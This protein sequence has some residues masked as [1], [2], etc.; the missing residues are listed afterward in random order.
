RRFLR[1]PILQSFLSTR[2][3]ML[4]NPMLSDLH[5]SLSNRS[6]LKV[7]IEHAKNTHFPEGTGWKGTLPT[8][9]ARCVH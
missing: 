8:L 4:R 7:Y 2:Y 6:H 9:L 5:I 3:P 1:H